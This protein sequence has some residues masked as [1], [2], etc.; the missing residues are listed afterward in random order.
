MQ[1]AQ[2]SRMDHLVL[3]TRSLRQTRKSRIS[4]RK[5]QPQGWNYRKISYRSNQDWLLSRHYYSITALSSRPKAQH[6]QV[7]I[8]SL[9]KSSQRRRR[10][11]RCRP[12]NRKLV[13]SYL[14]KRHQVKVHQ[15]LPCRRNL[16]KAPTRARKSKLISK[17]KPSLPP[18]SCSRNRK[19]RDS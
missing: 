11:R 9:S 5:S 13:L 17:L 16:L 10:K 7:K 1:K 6:I 18:Q 14:R 3:L 8:S 19:R 15:N 12:N 4:L 2:I